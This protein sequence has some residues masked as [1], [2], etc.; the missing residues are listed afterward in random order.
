MK[1]RVPDKF[2]F[3]WWPDK[4]IFGSVRIECTP[5]ERGIW[6]DLLSLASKDDGHIRANEDTPY[7]LEQLSGMLIIPIEDL[8]AAIT[9]FLTT[10]KLTRLKS[11]TLYI[12]KWD[13]Y[14]FT[15]RHKRRIESE[16]SAKKDIV[17][18]KEAPILN[19]S[20]LNKNILNNKKEKYTKAQFFLTDLLIEKILKNDSKAK[21]PKKDTNQY[22]KWVDSI[23]FCM[24]RDGRSSEEI[25]QAIRFSQDSD[26]WKGNILSTAKLRKQMPTLLLQAQREKYDHS[27]VQVGQSTKK[28]TP[29]RDEYYKARQKKEAEVQARYKKEI[30]DI[31][32]A[33]DKK[34]WDILQ[35]KIADE[36]REW[37]KL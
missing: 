14:Q 10:E 27:Q 1:K 19:K 8:T 16:M 21:T 4:W 17:S 35:E 12:T 31:R 25:Q 3:P 15:D 13:K 2:W 7:P 24:E 30:S 11:G 37:Y 6:V 23:R 5:A 36:L 26:F 18:K 34:A 28:T 22:F 20:T 29:E 9:K 33:G 32:K